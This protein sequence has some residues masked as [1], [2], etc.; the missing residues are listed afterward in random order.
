MTVRANVT[1]AVLPHG[2]LEPDVFLQGE[3]RFENGNRG[4]QQLIIEVCQ[5]MEHP[6]DKIWFLVVPADFGAATV[7][8]PLAYYGRRPS[9]QQLLEMQFWGDVLEHYSD[10]DW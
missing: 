6:G 9:R 2:Q 1:I 5:D 8:E 3:D 10:T 4:I 7:A